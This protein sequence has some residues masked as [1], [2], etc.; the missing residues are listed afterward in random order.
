MQGSFE[1]DE[2]KEEMTR[3]ESIAL[4]RIKMSNV[5]DWHVQLAYL[6]AENEWGR[7][8]NVLRN[9]AQDLNILAGHASQ[10]MDLP[11]GPAKLKCQSDSAID[12]RDKSFAKY[13]EGQE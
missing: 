6:V 7:A 13:G 1:T 12:L 8:A 2:R 9:Y 10:L 3:T 4:A 5:T 11:D